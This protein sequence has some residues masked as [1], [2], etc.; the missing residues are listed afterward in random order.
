[1]ANDLRILKDL[2][3][4]FSLFYELSDILTRDSFDISLYNIIGVSSAL[5]LSKFI[6]GC[7]NILAITNSDNEAGKVYA[8][9]SELLP[10]DFKEKLLLFPDAN[11]VPYEKISPPIELVSEQINVLSELISSK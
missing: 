2:F 8:N 1:M 5:I 10:E 6:E 4:D 9:L 11:I 3:D 7:E